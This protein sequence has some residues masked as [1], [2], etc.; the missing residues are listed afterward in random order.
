MEVERYAIELA[1]RGAD[2]LDEVAL[3][4]SGIGRQRIL[5]TLD[6][7]VVERGRAGG[8]GKPRLVILAGC[9]GGLTDLPLDRA[10]PI[11]MVVDE[12]GREWTPTVMGPASDDVEPIA[13]LG[14]DRLIDEP[15]DKRR[16]HE[17]TGASI[18]DMESHAFA[19][20]CEEL[21]WPWA[22]VRGISDGPDHRVPPIILTWV[23][24]DGTNRTGKA[25]MDLLVRPWLWGQIMPLISHTQRALELAGEQA[26]ELVR[27]V[28]KPER[29]E[30]A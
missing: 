10:A 4:R 2:L 1:L 3:L 20:R 6:S 19:R 21:G 27:A 17:T 22:V 7:L 29:E 16:L 26:A 15:A 18:V 11:A 5:A 9:S 25:L 28:L 23:A 13:V 12:S 8:V 30:D 24:E 14:V